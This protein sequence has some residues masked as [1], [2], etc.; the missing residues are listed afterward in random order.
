[1]CTWKFISN[2]IIFSI[3]HFSHFLFSSHHNCMKN[4]N[5]K[6]LIF[7]LFTC[8]G[9]K[10]QK[11]ICENSTIFFG[12][13]FFYF[14]FILLLLNCELFFIAKQMTPI[15]AHFSL[16]NDKHGL[17]WHTYKK[18]DENVGLD[19]SLIICKLHE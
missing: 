1:L 6:N 8:F 17:L 10:S 4:N 2:S 9:K 16:Y 3:L 18:N 13:I 5:K 11:K 12:S 14:L 15:H 7:F 19:I